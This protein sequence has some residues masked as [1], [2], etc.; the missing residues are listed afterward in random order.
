MIKTW[1]NRYNGGGCSFEVAMQAEIDELRAALAERD[2]EIERMA[3]ASAIMHRWKTEDDEMIAAQRKVLEQAL[4]ALNVMQ[5]DVVSTPNAYEA[6]RQAVRAI[7]E[8]LHE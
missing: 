3:Q 7:Q 1:E 8:V 6:Q 5:E 2:A 4:E